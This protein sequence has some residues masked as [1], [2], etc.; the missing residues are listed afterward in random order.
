MGA[1]DIAKVAGLCNW[2]PLWKDRRARSRDRSREMRDSNGATVGA[3]ATKVPPPPRILSSL[4]LLSLFVFLLLSI[5][6]S[7][8]LSIL[9]H[10]R[11]HTHTHTNTHTSNS[12]RSSNSSKGTT[13]YIFLSLSHSPSIYLSNK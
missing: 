10:T 9:T 12:N 13:I 4:C 5:Y 11:A 6:L 8:Y 1:I 7:I 2:K 3:K